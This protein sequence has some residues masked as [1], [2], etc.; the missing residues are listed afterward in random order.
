MRHIIT[1]N[2]I[3]FEKY[4]KS[5]ETFYRKSEH[6]TSEHLSLEVWVTGSKVKVPNSSL[7]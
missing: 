4:I 7:Y 3:S 5:N 1:T 6:L 2:V